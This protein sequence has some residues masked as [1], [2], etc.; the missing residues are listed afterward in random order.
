[1]E[2]E[3]SETSISS[4]LR[5]ANDRIEKELASNQHCETYYED[6]AIT[7][8]NQK[9]PNNMSDKQKLKMINGVDLFRKKNPAIKVPVCCEQMGIHFTTYYK[10]KKELKTL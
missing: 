3:R 4:F 8:Y 1:M 9:L 5:W 6:S 2:N 10:W 7:D